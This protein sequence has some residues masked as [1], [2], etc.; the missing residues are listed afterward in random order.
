M[1]VLLAWRRQLA[2]SESRELQ[3]SSGDLVP[4]VG[5]QSSGVHRAQSVSEDL[6][7]R[8][9][10][11]GDR[12]FRR[13]AVVIVGQQLQALNLVSL[14]AQQGRSGLELA[15][16]HILSRVIPAIGRV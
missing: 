13:Q 9:R 1:S 8:E 16:K 12:A 5:R 6:E 2:S 10:A 14:P 11:I 15:L 3:Q 4:H 7:G